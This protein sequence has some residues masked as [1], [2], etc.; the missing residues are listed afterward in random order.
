M[1]AFAVVLAVCLVLVA[2]IVL[3]RLPAIRTL[4]AFQAEVD[5][6]LETYDAPDGFRLLEDEAAYG[7]GR[8]WH[9]PGPTARAP[10]ILF[11]HGVAPEGIRDGRILQ[12]ARAF[13]AA[14]FTVVVPEL[15][16]LVDPMAEGRPGAPVAR[17]LEAMT[18]GRIS[19]VHPQRIGVVA[20]S[21]GGGF[22]LRGCARFRA[23]G[24][25]G[26]RAMLL[27][28]AA[29]D[30]RR[31]AVAWFEA[32]DHT[33]EGDGSLAWERR[34]AASFARN[35]LIRAG[36]VAGIEHAGDRAALRA[37]MEEDVLPREPLE[38]LETEAARE[39]ARLLLAEPATRAA[40]REAVLAGAAARVENLSPALWADELVHLRGIAVF[41]LH[42]HGDP[43]VPLDEAA[44]LA[45]RLRPHTV[46]SVLE[47]HMVGHTSVNAAGVGEKLAH[48]VQMD[49]FFTMI[50]R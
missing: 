39:I 36:L 8:A 50:G 49:D 9:L 21:V 37:W 40:A 48:V 22:A 25:A 10:A 43:L 12:A 23:D 2:A 17:V 7:V 30:I 4:L 27:I 19:H 13:H 46:V 6:D 14:G 26:V 15:P 35:F 28:G 47:S 11:L 20:I 33:E 32:E 44:R 18:A 3:P 41:L 29:D 5:E 24:G 31:P 16:T 1:L 38:G 42:G 45:A 34:N